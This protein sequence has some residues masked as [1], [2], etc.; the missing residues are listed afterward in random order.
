MRPRFFEPAVDL[1]PTGQEVV[2]DEADHMEAIGDNHRI[3]K[4]FLDDRSVDSGQIH[5][6]DPDLLF[7]FKTKEIGV[8]GGF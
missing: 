6:D 5:A 1:S 4:L 2:V 3:G 7:A 8:Q